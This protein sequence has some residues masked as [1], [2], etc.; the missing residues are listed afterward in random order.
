MDQ[1]HITLSGVLPSA[2]PSVIAQASKPA[3]ILP[4]LRHLHRI[5]QIQGTAPFDAVPR[6]VYDDENDEDAVDD[7]YL[8]VSY[9]NQLLKCEQLTDKLS[10][11][12]ECLLG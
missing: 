6:P 10:D 8:D 1:A 3:Y 12:E 9:S 7:S 2:A 11:Y 4:H 5:D